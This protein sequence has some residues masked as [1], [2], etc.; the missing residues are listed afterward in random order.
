MICD[1][2]SFLKSCITQAGSSFEPSLSAA[3][4]IVGYSSQHSKTFEIYHVHF[5][6]HVAVSFDVQDW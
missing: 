3:V 4:Q 5:T 6:V 2:F 1:I